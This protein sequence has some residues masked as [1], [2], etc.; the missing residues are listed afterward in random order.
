ML[1][2]LRI[3]TYLLLIVALF[4]TS[5]GQRLCPAGTD[6][7]CNPVKAK[8]NP[9]TKRCELF[10]CTEFDDCR[11]YS[12]TSAGSSSGNG[13]YCDRGSGQ[14]LALKQDNATCFRGEECMGFA[15]VD[16]R[17]STVST[18][19][20][21]EFGTKVIIIVACV[22]GAVLL[23]G[24]FGLAYCCGWCCF[25]GKSKKFNLPSQFQQFVPQNGNSS[26]PPQQYPQNPYSY[27]P[28]QPNYSYAQQPPSGYPPAQPNPYSYPPQ[29]PNYS[30]PPSQ[31]PYSYPPKQ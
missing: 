28:Q 14:C 15:C 20:I 11:D 13:T 30:Y 29:Q 5:E 26:P 27:P 9:T 3:A 8:C 31:E 6:V 4:A 17:C 19:K 2:I 18:D 25:K 21:I 23:C 10:R 22:V 12:R 1:S 7:E 16:G 24:C